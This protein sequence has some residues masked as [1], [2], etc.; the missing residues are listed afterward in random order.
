MTAWVQ[1]LGTIGLAVFPIL[2]AHIVEATHG[3]SAVR[4]VFPTPGAFA[5]WCL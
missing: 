3:G 2:A 1:V 4:L 5:A